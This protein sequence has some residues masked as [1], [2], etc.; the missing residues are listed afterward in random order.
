[1]DNV[2]D[3]TRIDCSER[4]GQVKHEPSAVPDPQW[5][6]GDCPKCKAPLVS[7][8]YYVGGKGY[9]IRWECWESLSIDGVCD[10]VYVV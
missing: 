4:K 7:N 2:N 9:I 6:R 5:V 3:G 8:L 10:Y 1:M